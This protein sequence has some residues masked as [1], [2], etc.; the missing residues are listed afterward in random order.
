MMMDLDPGAL[1]GVATIAG[2]M[3]AGLVAR[4]VIGKLDQRRS[5]RPGPPRPAP[6][7]APALIR[8]A[9]PMVEARR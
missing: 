5:D 8:P 1:S 2:S 3:V 9:V 7:T 6:A 4:R